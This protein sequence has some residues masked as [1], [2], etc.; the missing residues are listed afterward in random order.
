MFILN[1]ACTI[2]NSLIIKIT[3]KI[4]YFFTILVV[5]FQVLWTSLSNHI[6]TMYNLVVY[7]GSLKKIDFI[8]RFKEQRNL[9]ICRPVNCSI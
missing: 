3:Y 1:R 9:R 2:K 5:I 6:L 4:S 7:H 8:V